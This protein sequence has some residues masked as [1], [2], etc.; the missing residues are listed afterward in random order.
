MP[1]KSMRHWCSVLVTVL[2]LG[3]EPRVALNLHRISD[4]FC[5]PAFQVLGLQS[6]APTG[7]L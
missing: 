5:L 2:L 3:L 1:I 6:L 7:G 4:W